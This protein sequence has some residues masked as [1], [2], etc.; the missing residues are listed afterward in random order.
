LQALKSHARSY[1]LSRL[2][3]GNPLRVIEP[4]TVSPTPDPSAV[5]LT[6]SEGQ[7]GDFSLFLRTAASKRLRAAPPA[8]EAGPN[9]NSSLCLS[10][11][12]TA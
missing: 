1:F 2:T 12:Q 10:C 3:F 4:M 11:T 7:D 8:R 6:S 5:P 9:H